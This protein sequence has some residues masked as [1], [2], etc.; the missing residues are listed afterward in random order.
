MPAGALGADLTLTE[1]VITAFGGLRIPIGPPNLEFYGT[2]GARYVF[3][4]TKL[5]LSTPLGFENTQS[6][7]KGWV[8]P[9]AGIAGQ[10]RFDDRW[11]MNMLADIGGWSDS[12]TGQALATIGLA[13]SPGRSAIA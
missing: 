8:N 11:F 9:V 4:G 3:S 1:G 2:L 12:A 6:V 5:T 7:N 13:T 10:Y